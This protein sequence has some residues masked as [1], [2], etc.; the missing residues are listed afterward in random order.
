MVNNAVGSEDG[1]MVGNA[2]DGID[3]GDGPE[4]G[5]MV[6]AAYDVDMD[7]WWLEKTAAVEGWDDGSS[8][9]D[10]CAVYSLDRTMLSEE[11]REKEKD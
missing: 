1:K 4:N 3:V 2:V 6:D 8:G 11:C 7:C 5:A 9:R 10:G